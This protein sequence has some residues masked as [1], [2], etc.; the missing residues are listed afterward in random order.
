LDPANRSTLVLALLGALVA[1]LGKFLAGWGAWGKG[2]RHA[3]IGAG[4]VPRGEVGLIFATVGKQNGVLN[5]AHYAALLAVIFL[6]TF[7]APILLA[8]FSRGR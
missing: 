3:L 2:I 1:F 4:M 7:V 5:D 8:S 6:T